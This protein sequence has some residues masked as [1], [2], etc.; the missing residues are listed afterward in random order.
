MVT[1][2][3]DDAGGNDAAAHKCRWC[4]GVKHSGK[5][6]VGIMRGSQHKGS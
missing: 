3:P 4:A 5:A 6:A 2:V 1:E